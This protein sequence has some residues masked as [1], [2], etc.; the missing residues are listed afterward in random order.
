MGRK[1]EYYCDECKELFGERNHINIKNG[2][3]RCSYFEPKN[4]EW[5]QKK[6]PIKC[7]EYHFCGI[8]CL[9]NWLNKMYVALFPL[10]E[11][12]L[13]IEDIN[14]LHRDKEVA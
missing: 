6:F 3:V 2:D 10:K 13:D 5:R 12:Q 11:R 4:K 7:T 14:D 9:T 8:G 1:V